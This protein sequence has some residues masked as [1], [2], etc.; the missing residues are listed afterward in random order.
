MEASWDVRLRRAR[1]R[2]AEVGDGI[3]SSNGAWTFGGDVPA[4]FDD[5][6]ARSI[7]SYAA[8]HDLVVDIAD[9]LVPAHG[10]CYDLGC[11]TGVLTG[12]LAERLAAR[13][14]EVIGIDREPGMLQIATER[15][16]K[17]PSVRFETTALEDL[18]FARA[19]LVVSYYT[20]QFVP[21]ANRQQVVDRIARALEPTGAL[22]LFEKVLAPTARDQEMAA[23][24]YVD[25]KRRQGYGDDEIGA[26]TRSLRGVL[27]PLSHDENEEML[28]RAGFTEMT[29]VF[30]WMIF[31][32][33]VAR[34]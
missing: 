21:V 7:P 10:R 12:R 33:L 23:G 25:W 5:H 9:H 34:V 27:S 2:V 14:A 4:S 32:G 31:D 29:Q 3:R 15:C 1:S 17:L 13:G 11:S 24:V 8:C 19:D 18:D 28:R 26:K 16:A 20:L 22:L 30:R 6:I